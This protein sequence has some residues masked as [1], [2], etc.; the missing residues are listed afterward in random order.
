[1]YIARQPI[2]NRNLNV[3]AYELLYRHSKSA[4]YYQAISPSS[5]TATIVG[6]LF[7]LDLDVLLDSK[8][9][10][11]NVDENFLM[12]ASLELINPNLLVIELLENITFSQSVIDRVKYLKNLGYK[13]ALDDF[14]EV[15]FSSEVIELI[16]IIKYDISLNPLHT[17]ADSVVLAKSLNIKVL[18][19]KVENFDQYYD[20]K[21]MG[22]DYFQGFFFSKPKIVGNIPRINLKNFLHLQLINEMNKAE[23]SIQTMA[24]IIERDA[25]LAYRLLRIIGKKQLSSQ[26]IISAILHIGLEA[27]ERWL[28][29]LILQESSFDEDE[30]ILRLSLQRSKF[31]ELIAQNGKFKYKVNEIAL[32]CL[33]S[34]IDAMMETS[35]ELAILPLGLDEQQKQAMIHN[36]GPYACVYTLVC[37]YELLN[38]DEIATYCDK[39]GIKKQSISNYYM[40]AL[41]FSSDVMKRMKV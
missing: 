33:L 9:G 28:Y 23:P 26:T 5:A 18:A 21:E 34:I 40:L 31:A 17:L 36:S 35:I 25:K 27:M 19:E 24:K 10:F 22:F 11:I 30:N 1:M 14:D 12:D 16:D 39:I 29:L 4:T 3:F 8:T 32:M 38:D 15:L 20:A 41:K 37:Q 7:E 13:F 2:L 6:G